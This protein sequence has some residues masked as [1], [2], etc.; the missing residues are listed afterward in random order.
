MKKIK[1]FKIKSYK[2]SSGI[3]TPFSFDKNYPL[4]VKRIF[5]ING[6][7]N[8]IRGNHAHKKCSQLFIAIL[9]TIILKIQT[10]KT[11]KNVILNPLKKMAVLVPP[12]YWC[13]IKFIRKNS[14][15]MTACDRY[16]EEND[17]IK[18]FNEYKKY[19]GN[20]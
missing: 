10:P 8:K 12:N 9:G 6:K 19:L 15:L 4:R 14:I 13:S 18:N 1:I 11:K 20:K 7:Q 2:N 3:L 17:Y 16:Y 5:L